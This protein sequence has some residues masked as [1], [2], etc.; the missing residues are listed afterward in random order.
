MCFYLRHGTF[1]KADIY[2]RER[3]LGMQEE[4]SKV[5]CLELSG[6]QS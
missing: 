4:A 2:A 6:V 5:L 1:S 3:T